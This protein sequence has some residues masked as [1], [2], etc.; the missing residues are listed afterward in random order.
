MSELISV[1]EAVRRGVV[2]IRKPHWACDFT[3]LQLNY[4]KVGELKDELDLFSPLNMRKYR[5][6]PVP[7]LKAFYESSFDL[8]EFV[9]YDGPDATSVQYYEEI[10]RVAD[11]S[12]S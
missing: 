3:Y 2:K 11:Q 10:K 4:S 6:D 1:N 5:K 8:N 12:I 7:I 9:V